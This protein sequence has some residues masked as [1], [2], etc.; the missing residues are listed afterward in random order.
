MGRALPEADLDLVRLRFTAELTYGDIGDVLGK[1][2][3]AVRKQL[4]RLLARMQ[5]EMEDDHA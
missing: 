1:S 2:D 5:S 3:E 4:E